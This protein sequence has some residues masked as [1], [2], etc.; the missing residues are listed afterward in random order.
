MNQDIYDE[1]TIIDGKHIKVESKESREFTKEELVELKEKINRGIEESRT[2]MA[3]DDMVK[4]YITGSDNDRQEVLELLQKY[5]NQDTYSKMV[6]ILA[7]ERGKYLE[8]L[9]IGTK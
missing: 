4:R 7:S 9:G 5:Y 2:N 1:N 3:F 8:E 6:E